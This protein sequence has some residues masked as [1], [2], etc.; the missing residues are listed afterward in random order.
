[1]Q[2]IYETFFQDVSEAADFLYENQHTIARQEAQKRVVQIR[3]EIENIVNA[4]TQGAYHERLIARL[5]ALREE[6]KSLQDVRSQTF[7]RTDILAR[8][9]EYGD[10]RAASRDV[11]RRAVLALVDKVVVF[12]SGGWD[13]WFCVPLDAIS[14]QNMVSSGSGHL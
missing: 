4:I 5:N 7:S 10:I 12:D 8:L 2:T 6:E 3:G 1:M 9:E 11:Q 14:L 13:I